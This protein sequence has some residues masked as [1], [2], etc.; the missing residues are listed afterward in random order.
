MSNKYTNLHDQDHHT[1]Q[2]HQYVIKT[3]SRSCCFAA[4]AFQYE[5]ILHLLCKSFVPLFDSSGAQFPN[6][7]WTS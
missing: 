5:Y 2:P 4:A 7:S 6:N 1:T 3:N